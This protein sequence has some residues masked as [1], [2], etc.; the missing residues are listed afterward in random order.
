VINPWIQFR[1]FIFRI[2]MAA[3]VEAVQPG[4]PVEGQVKPIKLIYI[5]RLSK[6]RDIYYVGSSRDVDR[7]FAQ[8]A[9]GSGCAWTKYHASL[10]RSTEF[11]IERRFEEDDP[12]DETHETEKLMFRHGIHNVRGGIYS[13]L[14]LPQRQVDGLVERWRGGTDC[15]FR[16]GSADHTV[17]ACEN[18]PTYT[19]PRELVVG[20]GSGG[21]ATPNKR[22]RGTAAQ[23]PLTKVARSE[24]RDH[25]LERDSENDS[26]SSSQEDYDDFSWDDSSD[27]DSDSDSDVVWVDHR[28]HDV[29]SLSSDDEY[30]DEPALNEQLSRSDSRNSYSERSYDEHS[31]GDNYAEDSYS[32]DGGYSDDQYSDDGY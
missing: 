25:S 21:S 26:E 22:R 6:D 1:F 16:C 2:A 10:G 8:H 32:S 18:M 29:I 4:V 31:L 9:S 7:R 20:A 14:N 30:T 5:L 24:T 11:S 23:Q 28:Q 17:A 3:Y 13:K 19:L 15:C 12:N 27:Y